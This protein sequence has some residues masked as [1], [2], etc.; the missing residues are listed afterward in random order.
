MHL[1]FYEPLN[2]TLKIVKNTYEKILSNVDKEL[3][4]IEL[5]NKSIII[6]SELSIKLI[7]RNLKKIRE[8]IISTPFKTASEEII[9]FKYVKPKFIGKLIYF[10][11]IF[12]IQSKRPPGNLKFQKKYLNNEIL[13]FQD[14][15][16]NN[17][18]LYQYFKKN[19]C[20]L[21]KQYFLRNKKSIRIHSD[22]LNSYFDDSFTT[23]YDVTFAKF[24]GFELVIRYLQNEI[25]TLTKE[26]NSNNQFETFKSNLTWTGNKVGLVE[27]I[28]AL[29]SVGVINNG[30]ADIKELALACEQGLN[31]DLGDYYRTFLEIRSRKMNN[32]KFIDLLKNTLIKRIEESDK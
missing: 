15:Y 26:Q 7:N 12:N 23:N 31:I 8:N 5:E 3:K 13:K 21:D 27:L 2:S 29:H 1:K 16:M 4:I 32:T 24:I 14:Y 18:E 9:F 25:Q 28:Y 22:N 19:D 17:L 6:R 30:T 10:I 20:K 11:E